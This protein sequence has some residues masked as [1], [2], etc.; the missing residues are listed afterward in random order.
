MSVFN[1]IN[2]ERKSRKENFLRK[3]GSEK[4]RSEK[5]GE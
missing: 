5:S 3:F 1:S 2:K 4:L